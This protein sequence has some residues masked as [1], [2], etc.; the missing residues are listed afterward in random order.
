MNDQLTEELVKYIQDLPMNKKKA[1]WELLHQQTQTHDHSPSKTEWVEQL[2]Q[3]S[4]WTESELLSL[5][6]AR[7]YINQWNPESSF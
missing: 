2:R 6:Q 1:L 5:Q 3:L 7:K 4:V